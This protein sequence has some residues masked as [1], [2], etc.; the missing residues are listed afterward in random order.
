MAL[1]IFEKMM[2]MQSSVSRSPVD[3]P[4]SKIHLEHLEL[5]FPRRSY[6]DRGQF[7]TVTSSVHVRRDGNGVVALETNPAK[8]YL[9]KWP[10]YGGM[11]WSL[12]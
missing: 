4:S 2:G 1:K 3:I 11:L 10:E 6:E 9:P 5:R 12:M 8:A 7:W